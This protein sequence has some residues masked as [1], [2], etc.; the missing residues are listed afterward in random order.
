MK[1]NKIRIHITIFLIINQKQ[2]R[3]DAGISMVYAL[4]ARGK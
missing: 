1:I 4:V 3:M 2:T